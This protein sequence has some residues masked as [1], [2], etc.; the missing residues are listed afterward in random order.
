MN[1]LYLNADRKHQGGERLKMQ[2]RKG[3]VVNRI[4][5]TAGKEEIQGSCRNPAE[6]FLLTSWYHPIHTKELHKVH[7][8]IEAIITK[9]RRKANAFLCFDL[10][11]E[12]IQRRRKRG[13]T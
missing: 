10:Y 12:P 3:K 1:D 5:K 4:P 2:M 13:F 6:G 7:N 8:G 11:N 9:N